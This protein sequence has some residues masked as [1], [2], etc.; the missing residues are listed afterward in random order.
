MAFNDE[1]R[2]LRKQDGLTQSALAS[3]LG[4]AKSTISMYECGNRE[5]DFE[6]LEKIAD[7]FNVDMNQL[8]G[9]NPFLQHLID[10]KS[11]TESSHGDANLSAEEIIHGRFRYHLADPDEK[12]LIDAYRKASPADREIL[13]NIASRYADE[14]NTKTG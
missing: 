10:N 12:R 9:I 7:Y 6:T 13:D 1:L 8:T 11:N 5:P 4:I 3:A 2:R 14:K